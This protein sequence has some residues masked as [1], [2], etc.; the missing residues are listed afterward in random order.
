VLLSA[1]EHASAAAASGV[2]G[3]EGAATRRIG[4]AWA[5]RQRGGDRATPGPAARFHVLHE[6]FE[7]QADARPDAVA[8]V[9]GRE[10]ATYAAL[11]RHAN[12]IARHLRARGVRRGSRVAML[13]S[14]S[15]DAYAALLGILKAG[16]AY[17]PLD[18]ECPADRVAYI[19]QN[20]G[21][22]VLLT[23]AELAEP[24]AG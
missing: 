1:R 9:F 17:V 18:P 3:V 2:I 15:V 19:L 24:H 22:E 13:L 12:R 6:I 10:E 21:A 14:R 5:R 8:V 4:H 23:T 16:A 11:E 20:S 7:A